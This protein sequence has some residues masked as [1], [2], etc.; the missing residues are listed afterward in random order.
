VFV[1][2]QIVARGTVGGG[3]GGGGGGL[4]GCDR[5]QNPS[6]G[7]AG[8]A[9][10][11]GSSNRGSGRC[12]DFS[13]ACGGGTAGTCGGDGGVGGGGSGGGLLLRGRTI[14]VAAGAIDLRGG[15]ADDDN[16]GTLKLRY[17]CSMLEEGSL[18]GRV[19]ALPTETCDE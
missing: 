16:G 2:G 3:N 11:S 5:Y 9:T 14:E 6:G 8:R 12:F 15:R 1:S 7:S 18:V 13:S 17:G 19:H 10:A 4:S